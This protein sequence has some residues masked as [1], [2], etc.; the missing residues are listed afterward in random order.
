MKSE[1]II[2][3][4]DI[5]NISLMEQTEKKEEKNSNMKDH[6]LG[7]MQD[8]KIEITEGIEI[9]EE[10]LADINVDKNDNDSL[11]LKDFKT[12]GEK[13]KEKL[14]ELEIKLEDAANSIITFAD[15]TFVRNFKILFGVDKPESK[16]I[17]I[18]M[19]NSLLDFDEKMRI[20]K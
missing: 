14:L 2:K 13:L 19:L 15:Q 11:A 4:Q 8:L 18:S 6:V 1:K 3:K 10:F 7:I 17:L 9:F 12:N 20:T 16:I 5:S